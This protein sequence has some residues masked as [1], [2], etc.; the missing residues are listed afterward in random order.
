MRKFFS[1]SFYFLTEIGRKVVILWNCGLRFGECGKMQACRPHWRRKGSET[2]RYD[3]VFFPQTHQLLGA[4]VVQAELDLTR[5]KMCWRE[6]DQE[7][8]ARPERKL[9]CWTLGSAVGIEVSKKWGYLAAK[10]SERVNE[11]EVQVG[12]KNF[13]NRDTEWRRRGDMKRLKRFW[14]GGNYLW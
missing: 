1:D 7:Y 9:Q 8:S 11:W 5:D 13:W 2:S 12:L 3:C 4:G 6:R 14:R 10:K